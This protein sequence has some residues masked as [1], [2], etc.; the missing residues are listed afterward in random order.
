DNDDGCL[1]CTI[2]LLLPAGDEHMRSGLQIGLTA[3]D[4]VDDFGVARD[5]NGLLAILVFYLQRVPLDFLHL[6][7]DGSI[8]H[9]AIGHQV[10]WIV[11]FAGPTKRLFKNVNFNRLLSTIRL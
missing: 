11:P 3:S 8:G 10:P 9:G 5:D 2:A 6:L 1:P 4:K 7:R